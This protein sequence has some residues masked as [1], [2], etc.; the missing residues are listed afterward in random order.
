MR[1][2]G[3]E[4]K[5]QELGHSPRV[6]QLVRSFELGSLD[7]S[8][9]CSLSSSVFARGRETAAEGTCIG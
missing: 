7:F 9:L 1:S 6:I 2:V 5:A 3:E 8:L 4:T